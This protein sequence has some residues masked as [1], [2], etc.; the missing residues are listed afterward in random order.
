M[1]AEADLAIFIVLVV[2]LF[3]Q[4]AKLNK[5][6]VGL[7]LFAVGALV[8]LTNAALIMLPWVWAKTGAAAGVALA[9]KAGGYYGIFQ[10]VKN[11]LADKKDDNPPDMPVPPEFT[12]PEENKIQI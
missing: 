12:A 7:V 8:G 10:L 11:D 3:K 9:I 6:T 2:Q 4:R 1:F 5:I